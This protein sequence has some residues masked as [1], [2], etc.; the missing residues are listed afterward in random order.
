[1]KTYTQEEVD[2]I[3]K[4]T[5]LQTAYQCSVYCDERRGMLNIGDDLRNHFGIKL[6]DKSEKDVIIKP[7]LTRVK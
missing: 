3:Y 2:N 7:T 6:I 1:M 5:I 4:N